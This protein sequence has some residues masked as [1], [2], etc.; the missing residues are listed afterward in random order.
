MQ[1]YTTLGETPVDPD[2]N[3]VTALLA[4]ARLAPNAPAQ[5]YRSGETFTEISTRQMADRVRGIAKGLMALGLESGT[6][7]CL[8]SASRKEFTWCDYAIWMAGCTVVPIYES[9]A[10]DQV[11]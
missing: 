11:K 3:V 9:D 4:R 5:A 10:A 8:F 7:V 6:A 1:E 2:D